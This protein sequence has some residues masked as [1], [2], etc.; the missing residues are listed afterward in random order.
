MNKTYLQIFILPATICAI[1][2]SVF[3]C[4]NAQEEVTPGWTDPIAIKQPG[5][6]PS[7]LF[8]QGEFWLVFRRGGD[9]GPEIAVIRSQDGV[10]WSSPRA[11]VKESAENL[12]SPTNPQWLKRPDGEVW[13]VWYSGKRADENFM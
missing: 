7:L 3:V 1:S 6:C 12:L 10:E 5:C 2:F 8:H 11:L 9:E 4:L 13:L